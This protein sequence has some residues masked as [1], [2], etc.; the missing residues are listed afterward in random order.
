LK[1][2]L[3]KSAVI[4]LLSVGGGVALRAHDPIT[5]QITWNREISRVVFNRCASCHRDGGTA[6]SLMTYQ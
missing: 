1:L 3:A 6:F 2:D 5:T 4:V